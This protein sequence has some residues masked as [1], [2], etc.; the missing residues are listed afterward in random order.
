MGVQLSVFARKFNLKKKTTTLQSDNTR[1]Y[2]QV[3]TLRKN[4]ELIHIGLYI[5]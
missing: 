3:I 1:Y 4:D 2:D 5:F